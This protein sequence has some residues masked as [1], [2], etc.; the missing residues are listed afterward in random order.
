MHPE[1]IDDAL[2]HSECFWPLRF[3]AKSGT[4]GAD[5]ERHSR[6]VQK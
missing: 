1:R 6:G 2:G 5:D 4:M 3:R